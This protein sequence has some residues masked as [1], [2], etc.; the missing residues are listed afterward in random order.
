MLLH[1]I[2]RKIVWSYPQPGYTYRNKF[3]TCTV[4][5]K[6]QYTA[7]YNISVG[8]CLINHSLSGLSLKEP[9][10]P[11]SVWIARSVEASVTISSIPITNIKQ[12]KPLK[13]QMIPAWLI[14]WRHCSTCYAG[15]YVSVNAHFVDV[16]GFD[17]GRVIYCRHKFWSAFARCKISKKHSA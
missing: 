3:C 4:L 12:L 16:W 11:C 2:Q 10:S 15:I 13:L 17:K 9:V 14:K 5:Q 8:L 7:L 6:H 1:N